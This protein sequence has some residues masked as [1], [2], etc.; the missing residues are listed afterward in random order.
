MKQLLEY[1]AAAVTLSASALPAQKLVG[2]WQGTLGSPPNALRLVLRVARA[3][4]V[5][6]SAT[7]VSVDQGG[8]DNAIPIDSIIL[9]DSR[10]SFFVS[11]V[12]GSTHSASSTSRRTFGSRCSIGAAPDGR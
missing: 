1:L 9:R 11:S 12:G 5:G 4:N 10:V 8:W 7:L 3:S 2:N 6:M